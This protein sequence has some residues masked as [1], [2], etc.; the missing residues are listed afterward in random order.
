MS[1]VC[2]NCGT[3]VWGDSDT[4]EAAEEARELILNLAKRWGSINQ[5]AERFAERHG[6]KPKTVKRRFARLLA[7][8]KRLYQERFL[9]ELQV[10]L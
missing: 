4:R 6:Y 8:Q 7:G 2:P 10:M 9:D 1:G 5:A 3:K